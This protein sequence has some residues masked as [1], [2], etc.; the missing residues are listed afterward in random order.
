MTDAQ[1]IVRI[2]MYFAAGYLGAMG[3][4]GEAIALVSSILTGVIS[5]VWWF[6]A[7]RANKA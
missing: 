5:L 2:I 7:N 6:F 4:T 3:L 1:Q